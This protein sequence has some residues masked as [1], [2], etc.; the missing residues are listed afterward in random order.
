MSEHENESDGAGNEGDASGGL[1]GLRAAAWH[2]VVNYYET[3]SSL[4]ERGLDDGAKL[5]NRIANA[6]K[7]VLLK[8]GRE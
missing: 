7:K 5:A 6:I 1:K 8:H 3:S 4:S 2:D